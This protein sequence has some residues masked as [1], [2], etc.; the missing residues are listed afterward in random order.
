MKPSW[1]KPISEESIGISQK[2]FNQKVPL[3]H[4]LYDIHLTKN[5]RLIMTGN[6]IYKPNESKFREK[7]LNLISKGLNQGKTPSFE[8][9]VAAEF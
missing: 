5:D 9:G 7:N 4:L 6:R 8:R 2:P 3:N 1:I